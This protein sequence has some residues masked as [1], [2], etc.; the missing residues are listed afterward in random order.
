MEKNKKTSKSKSKEKSRNPS[1]NKSKNK[2]P[3]N[4]FKKSRSTNNNKNKSK[5]KI[6]SKSKNKNNKT[7]KKKKKQKKQKIE[8][9]QQEDK[10]NNNINNSLNNN[11]NKSKINL[12]KV[13]E[14]VKPKKIFVDTK[15]GTPHFDIIKHIKIEVEKKEKIINELTNIKYKYVNEL[16]NILDKLKKVLIDFQESPEQ[17]NK[18]QLLYFILNLN[19]KNNNETIN[20]NKSVK[21]EYKYL[22]NKNNYD[23]IERINEFRTKIDISQNENLGIINQIN[24]LKNNHIKRRNKL[25][26]FVLNE[27]YKLNINNLSNELNMLNN[28]KQKALNRLKNNKKIINSCIIKFQNLLK[29][30]EDYKKENINKSNNINIT[31]NKIDKDVNILKND[32]LGDEEQILNKIINNTDKIFIFK[33]EYFPWQN[34]YSQKISKNNSFKKDHIITKIDITKKKIIK[35]CDSAGSINAT[36]SY[37]HINT[38]NNTLRK[39][40]LDINVL[41]KITNNKSINN[42]N[43]NINNKKDN[44]DNI[45]INL[46]DLNISQSQIKNI[47]YLEINNKKENYIIIK[48]R[49][50]FSIKEAEN[51]YKRKINQVQQTLN[52]NIK[53]FSEIEKNNNIIKNEIQNL[54]K[55]LELQ[56]NYYSFDFELNGKNKIN[57]IKKKYE[58]TIPPSTKIKRNSFFDTELNVNNYKNDNNDN[59]DNNDKSN[60]LNEK[61]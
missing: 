30:Y 20:R 24:E 38:N 48:N 54:N 39:K 31:I 27:K 29:T 13:I 47:N 56:K 10:N 4:S 26:L 2:S 55:I 58:N 5:I 25:K 50:D 57:E 33:E 19:K 17:K 21:K 37:Q 41:P 53:K 44:E 60:I 34:K 35:R 52:E 28:E 61:K 11:R 46:E 23:P 1:S 51:M 40:F 12:K 18:I 3:K 42:N 22:L 14:V 49:L 36:K 32:L 15:V 43:N 8:I 9:V 16:K 7:S 6:K 45:N 59:N